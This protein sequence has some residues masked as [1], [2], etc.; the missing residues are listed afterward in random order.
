MEAPAWS[1]GRLQGR[2]GP[3]QGHTPAR[4]RIIVVRIAARLLRLFRSQQP[5]EWSTGRLEMGPLSL[6]AAVLQSLKAPPA[7]MA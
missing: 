7:S 2:V 4:P 5:W 1:S 3:F 6:F